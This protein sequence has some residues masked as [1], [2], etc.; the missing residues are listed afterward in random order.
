MDAY[1]S[2]LRPVFMTKQATPTID[3]TTCTDEQLVALS[4][5]N[6]DMYALLMQRFEDR[7]LRYIM[8]ISGGT[9]E[10]AQDILQDVFISAYLN[11]NDFDQEL[12]FSSWVYRIAHNK[13]ISHYRKVTAR[14][15]TTTYEGDNELLN[16]LASDDDLMRD[17]DKKYTAEQVR[18]ILDAMDERYREV[19]VLKF[20]EDKDY[21]ELSDILQKPMGTVATLINRAKKQFREKSIQFINKS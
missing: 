9:I 16:I 21:K 19:L 4:L 5:K 17:L 11:L 6:P 8:R 14:P 12:K 15:K 20:L 1:Q 13:V 7:L 3:V 18:A 2:L 10:D